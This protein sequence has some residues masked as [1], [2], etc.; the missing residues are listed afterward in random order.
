MFDSKAFL[1]TVPQQPGVYRMFNQG[2]IVI[3]VGKAKD[4]KKR[5]S[6]YFRT[7]VDSVKTRALVGQIASIEFTLTHSETEALIL[8]NNLI[9]QYLPKY[10]ILLRDDKSYPYILLTSHRH[11]RISSHRGPRKVVGQYFGPYPNAG[12]VWQSLKS[13]QKIFPIRQ[14]E[15]GFYR[16]RTRPCLQYQ[17]KLCS[18]PCVGKIS[19][20]DYAEQVRLAALFLAGKNQQVI[21]DLVQKMAAA[22]ESW[23]F[24][25]A[26]A[27]RDQISALRKV[28][29]QQYVSGDHEELDAIGFSLHGQTAVVHVLF[30]RDR[31]ILGSKSYYPKVPLDMSAAEVLS[32]FILQFYLNGHSEQQIPKEIVLPM[33]LENADSLAEAI[34]NIAEFKVR[35]TAAKRGEKAQY[36]SLAQ[37]NA[38]I[39]LDSRQSLTQKMRVRYQ[40]LQQ[41]LQLPDDIGRMECFD[42][43]HTM[44]QATIASCVVFDGEGPYKQE[45]RRYNVTGITG[46]DDYAAM[47][48]ALDKRYSKLSEVSKIPDIIFIDGGI[49]QLNIAL[50]QF[51]AWPHAKKPLLIGVAK[52]VSRKAGL[53]TLILWDSG[54]S[55]NLPEDSPALHLIQQ[56]R[57]EAH[58]FAITGHRNKRGKALLK[59]PLENISGIGEKRR[60]ALLQYLGGLQGVLKASV[61]ELCSVPGISKQQAEKIYQACQNK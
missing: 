19:D 9:K 23:Q 56:I 60:Q 6:S 32:A 24:E 11:P 41:L 26:A 20:E 54:R 58:R 21:D 42:I 39:A 8:E 15:D 52:G 34:S 5:L 22:S 12:A 37:K 43:S 44:G 13:L 33:A 50:E 31:K 49:G 40:A 3:Y 59:S 48:F 29:E 4:L 36:L 7:T 30:I 46:G 10:N 57:D 47:R 28:Q 35:L 38:Q 2:G 55:I 45:Y 25:A 27:F 61:T 14:C 18:A 53:E 17:L 51:S 16:A 1:A